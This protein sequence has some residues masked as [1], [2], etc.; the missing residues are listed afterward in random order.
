MQKGSFNQYR[1]MQN[2]LVSHSTNQAQ[3]PL[4]EMGTD[5]LHEDRKL[6]VTL[7]QKK[8]EGVFPETASTN[9]KTK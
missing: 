6:L 9:E 2:I 3:Q 8:N 4:N 5:R 1:E 7:A